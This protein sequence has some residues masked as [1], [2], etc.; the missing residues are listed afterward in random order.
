MSDKKFG[1][2]CC[3]C[4]AFKLSQFDFLHYSLSDMLTK[5]PVV[6]MSDEYEDYDPS[7]VMDAMLNTILSH[8]DVPG[9]LS[10]FGWY[11]ETD[12]N[13]VFELMPMPPYFNSLHGCM[14]AC[15]VDTDSNGSRIY[16]DF[17]TEKEIIFT[18]ISKNEDLKRGV[19]LFLSD[20]EY[21]S[22]NRIADGRVI[23]YAATVEYADNKIFVDANNIHMFGDR[24]DVYNSM[25]DD[26]KEW[27]EKKTEDIR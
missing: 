27:F 19:D 21:N 26:F 12:D 4:V 2:V 15:Y 7:D 8:D 17:N 25:A 13:I 3:S 20:E 16:K 1:L 22:Y 24:I 5:K 18:N 9:A 14:F 11:H 10:C 6:L 23:I